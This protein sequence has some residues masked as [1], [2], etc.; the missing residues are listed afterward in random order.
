M[1]EPDVG[2]PGLGGPAVG[3]SAAGEPV[4]GEHWAADVVASDGGT[5]HLR[6]L[7]P[8]DEAALASFHNALSIH[9]R[10]LR[11]FAPVG[12]LSD[13]TIASLTHADGVHRVV[14]AVTLGADII[15]MGQFDRAPGDT[16]AE[17]SFVVSDAHQGRGIGSVLLE[18][19]A[20][21]GREVGVQRFAAVVLAQNGA[22][23]RVFRDAGYAA[24]PHYQGS[25]V[26]LDF[27]IDETA[28]TEAVAREREQVSEARS[29]RRLLHPASVAVVGASN[30]PGKIG[31]A[32]F[33]ALLRAGFTGPLYP[34]NPEARSVHG[35][36]AYP[37]LADVPDSI[38]LVV[39]AV[40]AG[41]VPGVVEQAAQRRAH[42]LVVISG[43][44]AETGEPAGL[45]AQRDLLAAARAEGM[46]VV[47]PNCLGVANADPAVGLNA[48]LAPTIPLR[49]RAGF[50]CQSGALGVAL[51]G[52]A[53]RRGLGISS[54]VSAG[55]RVDVSG[56]DL[57]QYWQ[58]DEAT[59]IALL[60]LE[61]FG[62][63]RKF[64]RLARR[65]GR[66]KPVVVVKSGRGAPAA[67]LQ[68]T[69]VQL[70]D[71]TV[72]ALFERSGIIRVDTIT[73][74]FDV[75]LLLAAQPLPRGDRVAVVGNSSA[76]SGL[77]TDELAAEGL[78]LARVVDVGVRAG[79]GQYRAALEA[80]LRDDDVDAV[81][82]VF[83]PP[84]HGT[85]DHEVA[86]AIRASLAVAS[87]PVVSTFLGLDGV[88]A[89]LAASDD[90][91]PGSGPSPG[92]D[93]NPGPTPAPTLAPRPASKPAPGS[94]PSY[95]EPSRAVRALARAVRY[96]H[97]R[98][99]D[100]EPPP[101][102]TGV[103]LA[104]ARELVGEVLEQDPGG[105]ALS[106]AEAAAVLGAAGIMLVPWREAGTLAQARAA[107]DAVAGP[108]GAALRH[109][110]ALR[111]HLTDVDALE[112]AWHG[113]G[114][115]D[116]S[117]PPAVV[118]A[119]TAR[120]HDVVLELRDDPAFGAL[121]GFGAAGFG[122]VSRGWRGAGWGGAGGVGAGGVGVDGVGVD[123]GRVDGGGVDQGGAVARTGGSRLRGAGPALLSDRAFGIVPLT[124]RDAH[125][126]IHGSRAG[127]ALAERTLDLGSLEQLALRLSLLG[128]WLPQ[129][130]HCELVPVVAA[131]AG[132]AVLDARIVIRPATASADAGPRRL[133]GL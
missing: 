119:M 46:R 91:A 23:L 85:S 89:E 59:D 87:K 10:Y 109:N 42:A 67:G 50:F 81:V 15:A 121:V 82:A 2:E 66:T 62:N 101:R 5:V 57:L 112:R 124:E 115:G 18:H 125:E 3:E 97:W 4:V 37:T 104:P 6:P 39:V 29:I 84:I 75:A 8:G 127:Q 118:Q 128:E 79:A 16:E 90:P 61:S 26:E 44:F 88:P 100:V 129:I 111:L 114:L 64:A 34:V 22:M 56:N 106:R 123:E 19:L 105:R 20:A 93:P 60:Y 33:Q 17:V 107:F 73:D 70:P 14:L 92:L 43:G 45:A 31:S 98:G 51:L 65:L 48:T 120:G 72:D 99:Q 71:A 1:T 102:W 55:N 9:S 86:A 47:G 11:Y 63:P 68:A 58:S 117:S 131:D 25:E 30:D 27:A 126:L 116:V 130:A 108:T 28:A 122:A 78:A 40:P 95:A 53:A 49:G 12:E 36:R 38:D 35:V 52:E 133:R 7:A 54:F 103:D 113:L 74:M 110:G 69:S 96:A 80:A 77:V 13:A 132:A 32:V 24:R 21:A 76:L 94:V 41:A 83:V